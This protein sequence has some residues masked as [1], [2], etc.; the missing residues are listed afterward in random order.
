MLV[1]SMADEVSVI[2]SPELAPVWMS[3]VTSVPEVV[4]NS[5]LP[6]NLVCVRTSLICSVSAVTSDCIAVRSDAW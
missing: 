1:P 2:V 6:L 4:E 3:K 5:A